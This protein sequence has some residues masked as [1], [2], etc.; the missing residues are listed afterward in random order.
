MSVFVALSSMPGWAQVADL[1]ACRLMRTQRDGLA[2]GAMDQ[3][4]VLLRSLRGKICPDLARKAEAANAKV[5]G[6]V[7]LES[8]DFAAW[9]RCRHEAEQGLRGSKPTR[10]RNQK[11]FVFYTQQGAGLAEQADQLSS[12]LKA[13]GCP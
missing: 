13:S 7:P 1:Q 12:L 4:I 5:M 8:F 6:Y 9:N 10:Y 11:G 2:S 3:E